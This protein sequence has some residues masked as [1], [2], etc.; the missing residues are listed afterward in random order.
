MTAIL[1][2]R[3]REWTDANGDAGLLRLPR[4]AHTFAGFRRWALS[5]EVPEKLPVAFIRGEVLIEMSKE[6]VRSHALVKTGVAGGLF[7]L[8]EEVDLGHLFINGVLIT[9]E[10]ASVCNNPDLVA[11]SY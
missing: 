3:H 2:G 9:N 7:V 5:T 10:E 6:E 11:V 1:A 4:V 8:N